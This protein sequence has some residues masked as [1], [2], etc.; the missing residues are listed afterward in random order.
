MKNHLT[1]CTSVMVGKDASIDGST[2][3]AR[4]DDT[5]LPL[6]PQRFFVKPANDHQHGTWVSNQ[7]GF[8]APYP[9]KAQ[10]YM[11]TPNADVKHEGVFAESGFNQKNVAMSATESVYGNEK[12]LA[13]DPWVKNG[14]AEDSLQSMVLPY[15]SSAKDGVKYLGKLIKKYGSPEGNG[16]L[17]G[18]KDEVWY[19]EIVTGHQWVAERIPDDAYAVC[20]NEVAIQQVN[21]NDPDHFMWSP[22]IREFVK[23]NH[24]NPDKTGFNFR[25]IFGTFNRQD[26]YYNTPRVWYGQHLLNPEIKQSPV[27]GDLPFI[28]HTTHKISVED[29]ERI[30]GSHYNE[31]PYDP[32]GKGPKNLKLKFRP[33]AM[34]RT[35]NSHVLQIRN[36]VPSDRSAVMW[37]C[38]G[39]PAFSPYVPFFA[40]ANDTDPSYA[41]TPLHLDDKSAYWMYRKLSMLVESHYPQFSPEDADFL[42]SV[43]QKFREHVNGAIKDSK[44]LS[45]AKLTD[46]LTKQNHKIVAEMRKSTVKFCHHLMAE[47]LTLS[48]LTYDMDKNL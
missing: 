42:I 12:A 32:L 20:A 33:I 25:H 5:F 26:R 31:T 17:F 21:F 4:N 2:M 47:G 35:Q 44:D 37:L 36:D 7:N 3:I 8:K 40:N 11:L 22:N 48:K 29:I 19:M 1:A 13:C 6:T 38:F 15:I 14:L 27:S 16:V 18:D 39:V 34:N 46:Y 43:H 9:K 28:C 24:L 45:G 41:H 10:R 23:K 30:L